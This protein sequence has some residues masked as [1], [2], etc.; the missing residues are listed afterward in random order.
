MDTLDFRDAEYP[1]QERPGGADEFEDCTEEVVETIFVN[2]RTGEHRLVSQTR[3]GEGRVRR[4]KVSLDD[5]S[6]VDGDLATCLVCGTYRGIDRVTSCELCHRPIG[7]CCWETETHSGELHL[8]CPSCMDQRTRARLQADRRA[9]R[10]RGVRRIGRL[11]SI[12]I[13]YIFGQQQ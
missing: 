9:S 11:G 4:I 6:H 7:E 3:Y 8:F 2:A 13:V 5:G 1:E 10:Q 12:A